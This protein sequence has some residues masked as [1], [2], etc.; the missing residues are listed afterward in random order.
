MQQ[1]RNDIVNQFL[2]YGWQM[3]NSDNN[4]NN[5]NN[6]SSSSSNSV[7]RFRKGLNEIQLLINTTQVAVT[8]PID[9]IAYKTTFQLNN[10]NQDTTELMAYLTLHMQRLDEQ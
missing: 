4:N 2:V 10:N 3:K 5:N 1:L 6:N 9:D 8:V 7:S